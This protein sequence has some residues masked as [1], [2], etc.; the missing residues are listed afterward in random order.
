[1]LLW[2]CI[3]SREKRKNPWKFIRWLNFLSN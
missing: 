1:M 3:Y 2:T